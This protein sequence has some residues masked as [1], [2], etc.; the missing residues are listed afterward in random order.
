M[1]ID[2]FGEF[3][4]VKSSILSG[5]TD[6]IGVEYIPNSPDRYRLQDEN[7]N[8]AFP[9]V[10]PTPDKAVRIKHKLIWIVKIFNS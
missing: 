8:T 7:I 9:R 1:S 4:A 5:E 2:A 10:V 3:Y 6:L